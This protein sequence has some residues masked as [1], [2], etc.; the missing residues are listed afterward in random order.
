MG[1]VLCRVVLYEPSHRDIACLTCWEA[2][3]G[4]A[5]SPTEHSC[6]F[7]NVQ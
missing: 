4:K 3:V 6:A 2:Q 1:T 7:D 5:E